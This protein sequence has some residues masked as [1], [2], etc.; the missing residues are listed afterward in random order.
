MGAVHE[1]LRLDD[2]NKIDFLAQRR[3]S[4]QHLGIRR[5]TCPT[6]EVLSDNYH[7][8]PFCKPRAHA[9]VFGEALEQFIQP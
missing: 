1:N 9:S 7:H 6:G 3:V 5:H 4:R 2:G 8:P